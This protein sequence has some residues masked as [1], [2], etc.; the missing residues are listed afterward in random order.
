MGDGSSFTL[1]FIYTY[2]KHFALNIDQHGKLLEIL[3]IY[4]TNIFLYMFPC[5][6]NIFYGDRHVHANT[7]TENKNNEP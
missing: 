7:G 4:R 2:R 6:V 5:D 1:D 3:K